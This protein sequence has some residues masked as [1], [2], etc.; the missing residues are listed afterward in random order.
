MATLGSLTVRF[1]VDVA[2]L[3]AGIDEA[4]SSLGRIGEAVA[5]LQKQLSALSAEAVSISVDTSRIEAAS[6]SIDSLKS[7]ASSSSAE[8]SVSANTDGV[9]EL[10]ESVEKAGESAV[11]SRSS[12]ASLIVTSAAVVSAARQAA[13]SYGEFRDGML[14]FIQTATGA[15]TASQALEVAYRGLRGD[16]AALQA[17][18]GGVQAGISGMVQ[19]F[20]SAENINRMLLGSLGGVMRLFGATD[21]AV[22]RSTQVLAELITSQASLAASHRAVQRSLQLVGSAYDASTEALAR[23]LTQTATGRAAGEL[24]SDGLRLVA[25][26]SISVDRTIGTVQSRIAAFLTS[27]RLMGQ[28]SAAVGTA[29]D[30]LSASARGLL[31]STGSLGGSL[32]AIQLRVALLAQGMARL[33][34]S[35]TQVRA[36]FSS[37]AASAARL[38]PAASAVYASLSNVAAGL[39]IVLAAADK[40][41]GF[42]DFASSVASTTALSAAF[43]GLAGAATAAVS[44]TGILAGA[45]AGAGAALSSLV[46]T[47]P[48]VT[49]ASVAMAVATGK[50]EQSLRHV[51]DAAESLGNLSDRFGQPVQEIEKLEIAAE[52]S[53]V[54]MMSVVRAQQTFSQN[55]SKVKIGQLGTAQA[56]EAKAAFDRLGV[57]ADAMRQSD[58]QEV[59][60]L[61]AKRLSEI[62]DAAKRTQLAMDI[63]GR[64]GPQILPMLKNL[65]QLNA[66]IGRLGGTISDLD[67]ERFQ[68]VDQSFD[69]LA[70]SSKAMSDDLAIPFT[71]MG[72]AWNNA[73]AEVI[74]G[75]APLVGAIGEVIADITTP[76]AVV[77]EIVGR[78]VGTMFRLAAAV[79][80]VVTAFLS[81]AAVATLAELVGDAFNAIWSIVEGVA[82]AFEAFA[83]AVEETLRPSV[84]A[85]TAVGEAGTELLNTLTNF[86]GLGDVFG[87]ITTSLIALAT[88][89][90]VSTTATQVWSAVMAT[91][92]GVA[93]T[94]AVST[95]AAWVAA[96]AAIAAALLATAVVA[97]G[98]YVA[99]VIAATATTIA[100]CAAMHVA[101][102]FGLGPIGLLI[103]AIELVAVGLVA[104]YAL[105]SGVVEF[106][107]GWFEGEKAIDGAT[108]SV[109]ELAD[110]VAEREEPGMLKDL[111]AIGEAAG[112]SQE[113]VDAF[114]AVSLA[115]ISEFTGIEIDF[116]T[117]SLEETKAAIAG[118]RD[119]MGELSIRAAQLG[120]AGADA[121][122]SAAEQFNELQR[123]LAEGDVTLQQFNEESA[124]LTEELQQN[125]DAIAKG[126]PEETLKRNLEIFKQMD[127]AAKSAAKS[128]RDIGAGVQ[129][130]DKFFPRSDEV[131]ARAKQ[132]SQEYSDALDEIKKKLATGG[133]QQELDARR[134]KNE[135]D[136]ASGAIDQNTFNRTQQELDTTTAQEQASL[137]AEDVQRELDRQNAKLKV[138]LDFADSI[139]KELENAFLSPV[140][141]FEKELK[142]IRDNPELTQPEKDQA[143]ANLRRSTRESLIGKTA[144]SQLSERRFDLA[145]AV[146]SGIISQEQADFGSKKAM[147]EFA[148]SLGVVQT[149]FE[150]FSSSL[151]GIAEKFGFVGQPLDEVRRKLEGTPEQLALFDRALKESRDKLLASL[152]IEKSPEQV[153]Q[154]QMKR[155][156]EAVNSADPTKRI[157]QEEAAQA[158]AA[159]TRKRDSALGAGDDLGGQFADRQRRINEAFGSAEAGGPPRDATRLAIANNRL[160]I[161]R[162]QAAGLD[163]TP[164]QAVKAGVDKIND[165]FN[166]TGKSLAEIQATL[167][168]EKFAE[169]QEA[170]TKNSDAVKAS[171]GVEKSAATQFAESRKK[172]DQAVK[173]GIVS[174][175]EADLAIK[176]QRDSFLSS[177]GIDKSPAL[178]AEESLKKLKDAFDKGEISAEE[179]AEGSRKTKETLLSSLGIS[180]SP[181]QD[182]EDAVTKIR[183]SASAL[184]PDELERGLKEAKDKLLQSLGIDKS[185]AEAAEES[186]KKLREA[187]AKGQI[188]AEEFAKGSQKAKDSLLQSLGIPLDPV[189][190]LGERLTD[191]QDA[192]DKGLIS[193]EEL[194]RG[195]D[196]ARR[197]M[198]PGGEAESPVKKFQRDMDAVGRAVEEGLISEEDGAQR[199]LNLQA[200]LQEDLKPAL[201]RLQPDRRAVESSD[202]RSKEG[203]DTF[204]R[205]LRGNDNPSLKAQLETARNTKL[206]AE[207]SKDANAAPAIVQL[208]AR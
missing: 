52:Q 193:Q 75:L 69:R 25:R 147:E 32:A 59:L 111:R 27:G 171:L 188:S 30:S 178:A 86:L 12:I 189:T 125:L 43:G 203:V 100:S 80:K 167:G 156:D 20:A 109:D 184:S 133:F 87:P 198:L 9:Q 159:A 197:S 120:P 199:K 76:F 44:G 157:T 50:V 83:S 139:R 135:E 107:S 186:L 142:K 24:L 169:Y 65:E 7:K 35:A 140:Q 177:L 174:Q 168:P 71:R 115:A 113:E 33:L 47:I 105:G 166:V 110:A 165:A 99:S 137:A 201:E 101:W 183:K 96:G 4:I 54:A 122:A 36:A 23:F 148:Q 164:T 92:A 94:S 97:I 64:T 162:R 29:F 18:F 2:P 72:E 151:D 58:P 114:V 8:L 74:G 205:I 146:D 204:F 53:G 89:Y 37:L 127:D 106:F 16:L 91:S 176:K 19:S 1:G 185:P 103:A 170:I 46:A 70:T 108:A 153:F 11:R 182:F 117:S 48:L 31:G 143:E 161:D 131:K 90:F 62:P 158:R 132:Y 129:I 51:G 181:S 38:A 45:A 85:L 136:L 14:S 21:E 77:V 138:D 41:A 141:K 82:S 55:M 28:V 26:A 196:E 81:F 118:A 34:P 17:V 78:V 57:S 3:N 202:V 144:Q 56:R 66:D 124:R 42:L 155:I 200:Q 173:D 195:Q 149:P 126:S 119:A 79:V 39:G 152:G 15:R 5:G 22:V 180:R 61:V 73:Q 130:G 121:A 190:Q 63:F 154:E 192:F 206:L 6:K 13:R 98:A 112:V 67:F 172:L 160:D 187:F 104:L 179:F 116:G 84:E 95:A 191:L 163:A 145:D 60:A 102:L 88:A 68:A 128:A 49:V 194:T 123:S 93:I 134:K 10:G 175:E 208:Y 150:E 207:A 40:N